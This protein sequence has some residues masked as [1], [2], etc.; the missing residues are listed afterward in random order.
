[1]RT[2]SHPTTSPSP[3]AIS[4]ALRVVGDLLQREVCWLYQRRFHFPLDE[5][6]WT[7]AL[8]PESAG[9]LRVE[10]CR[11][12]LPVVTL[13]AREDDGARLADVVLE[14]ARHGE[15]ELAPRR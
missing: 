7:I 14:L 9:R 15:H 2:D 11:W 6:G 1:M 5:D 12:T 10:A 3:E 8:A 13:W 4:G